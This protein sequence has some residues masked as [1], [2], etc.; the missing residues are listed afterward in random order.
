MLALIADRY[1]G[2]RQQVC[3]ASGMSESRLAQLLSSSY[4]RGQGFGEKAARALEERL[5]L[6][7]LYFDQF[8]VGEM[9]TPYV[10]RQTPKT[11]A[12]DAVTVRQVV[13]TL[14]A[15]SARTS[16]QE[17]APTL[18]LWRF[19][20]SW[21]KAHCLHAD[22]LFAVTV[23]G[24]GMA[25]RLHEGDVVVV[26]GGDTALQDGAVYLINYRGEAILKRLAL[27]LGRWFMTAD[28]NAGKRYPRLEFD[29]PD[30]ILLGRVIL[31]ASE[32]I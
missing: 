23:T 1:D 10:V 15:G 26:N 28:N 5:H 9:T 6:D 22:K 25:P 4:R 13:L 2:D 14:T 18:C 11:D 24:A 16:M 17:I 27:D 30:C 3:D 29:Q 12:D 31:L 7:P 20:K 8:A 21:L 32:R 19:P